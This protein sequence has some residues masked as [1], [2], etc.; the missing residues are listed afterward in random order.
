MSARAEKGRSER[1][2][3]GGLRLTRLQMAFLLAPFA[4]LFIPFFVLPLALGLAATFTNYAPTVAADALR[5]VGLRNYARVLGD[6]L[7]GA[8]VRN[9]IVFLA[10]S[11][12]LELGL[13]FAIAYALRRPFRGR[14]V[15]RFWL[16]VP[17]L[18]SPV[19][20]GIMWHFLINSDQGLWAAVPRLFG[21]PPG[22]SPLTA[23]GALLVVIV[24]EA[25]RKTPLVT[26]LLLP[27][28]IS[29]PPE[30]WEQARLDGLRV[31]GTARHV[32][33]PAM[34]GLILTTALLM[35]GDGLGVFENI[36]MLTGGGPGEATFT[37]GFYSYTQAIRG[38]DW[39]SGTAAGWLIVVAVLAV[40]VGY[41]ALTR[42]EEQA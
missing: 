9:V 2:A 13:G 10:G 37:P 22:S 33:W 27:G 16:L 3:G 28:L 20:W 4:A 38:F 19:A 1:G 12:S 30:R 26:F 25:W 11:L 15:F 17:W 8:S 21:V 32:A 35:I 14:G 23:Q 5:F 6:S 18:V 34:R 7:F 40:G 42:R 36:L 39:R 41:I 29:V 31:F 24:T